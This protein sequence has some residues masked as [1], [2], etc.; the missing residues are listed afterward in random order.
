MP[1]PLRPG[2]ASSD[3]AVCLALVSRAGE[4]P[5]A[6][7]DAVLAAALP[8]HEPHARH[9]LEVIREHLAHAPPEPD[10]EALLRKAMAADESHDAAPGELCLVFLRGDQY[11]AARRG[12]PAAYLARDGSLLPLDNPMPQSPAEH[13]GDSGAATATSGPLSMVSGRVRNGDALVVGS[14]DLLDTVSE[15]HAWHTLSS[16]LAPAVAAAHLAEACSEGGTSPALA[17]L[18]VG[19]GPT[20]VGKPVPASVSEQRAAPSGATPAAVRRRRARMTVLAASVAGCLGLASGIGVAKLL[21]RAPERSA[22]QGV[23]PTPAGASNMGLAGPGSAPAETGGTS[24]PASGPRVDT[25]ASVLPAV[26]SSAA[27]VIAAAAASLP[28]TPAAP[29]AT[30]DHATVAGSPAGSHAPSSP[31]PPPRATGEAVPPRVRLAATLDTLRS[32]L[33]LFADR[34]VL[35]TAAYP[36]GIPAGR[37]LGIPCA[38]LTRLMDGTCELRFIASSGQVAMTL[39][40]EDFALLLRGETGSLPALPSGDYR[41]AWW[42]SG[43]TFQSP[44]FLVLRVDTL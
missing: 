24:N 28:T 35:Y 15:V 31:A 42:H 33:Q 44:P 4:P 19:R 30:G 12:R 21:R 22:S 29:P 37:P 10:P 11:W 39:R 34:G 27:G 5:L 25:E 9:V 38:P 20:P 17:V 2:C 23:A 14:T 13:D 40:P 1:V 7:I 32:E 18:Y 16:G 36:G 3:A 26:T 43:D 8:A 6:G 41:L